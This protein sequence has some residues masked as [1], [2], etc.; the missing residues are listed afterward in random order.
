MAFPTSKGT[1]GIGKSKPVL[2]TPKK[3]PKVTPTGDK[4]RGKPLYNVEAEGKTYPTPN[5][6]F[7][8]LPLNQKTQID[9]GKGGQRDRVKVIS[10]SGK[11]FDLSKEEY[12]GQFVTPQTMALDEELSK[13]P[14]QQAVQQAA[15]TPLPPV[16]GQTIQDITGQPEGD[17]TGKTIAA[18]APSILTAGFAGAG[19]LGGIG[20]LA[21]APTG[22]GA[23][24][25]GGIGAV[26]G[27]IGGAGAAI[28]AKIRADRK[29]D[30]KESNNV[31][32][33]SAKYQRK[34]KNYANS[35]VYKNNPSD[36][37]AEWDKATNKMR[38][39]QETLKRQTQQDKDKFIDANAG[40]ELYDVT[41]YIENIEPS[42]RLL[43]IATLGNPDLGKV[44]NIPESPEIGEEQ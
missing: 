33:E 12:G 37:L 24:I 15:G 34:L 11:T 39:V 6:Q 4:I 35:G 2:S 20:A 41:N 5:P 40:D 1:A 26:V 14:A 30:V 32:L 18:N 31:Y 42:E 38:I 10:P 8:P 3:K 17:S 44:E 13:T 28:F 21:G 19:T 43:F 23:P 16:E 22:I 36:A 9:F 29:Q 25:L 7:E 27:F